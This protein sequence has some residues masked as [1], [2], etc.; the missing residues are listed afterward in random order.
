MRVPLIAGNWKMNKTVPEAVTFV[1]ELKRQFP[2]PG[3]EVLLCPPFPALWP[4]AQAL[5]GTEIKVGAQNVYWEDAGAFTGEVSPPMLVATG[6]RYVIIGHSER[7]QYFGETDEQIARKLKA[8]FR[9]GLTPILCVGES[10]EIREQGATFDFIARQ[11]EGALS[12]VGEE[13]ISDLVVAYEPVWAIGTGRTAQPED[14]QEVSQ[15]IREWLAHRYSLTL[16]NTW[17]IQYGGSVTPDN[18][19]DLLAQPDIDGALVGGASLQVSS[20]AAIIKAAAK[21]V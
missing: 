21:E 7:R 15:N 2:F 19:A 13:E 1:E 18:A 3:V 6:C 10:L 12:R 11:L 16:A 5:A 8:A 17:R 9:H 20:F 14:A 4:V